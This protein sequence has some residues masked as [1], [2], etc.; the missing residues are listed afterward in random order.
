M[1]QFLVAVELLRH[2]EL[3]G[4]PVVVGGRGDPTERAVVS[5]A[6]YEARALR[7]PQRAC[8]SSRPSG[9]RPDAVFLPVDFPVYEAASARVM[10]T[11]RGDAGGR[12]RGARLGRG[13]RGRRDRR[14]GGHRAGRCRP[15]VLEATGLHCSVGIGDTLVRAKIATDF[16]KPQGV[17]E[18]TRDNWIEVMGERP[19][20]ALWGVGH[21]DRRSGSTQ[22]G[23]RTVRRPRGHRRRAARRR[24]RA[25]QRARTSAGSVAA[26]AAR[27]P[28]TPRGW[29][30]PTA[31]RR[32]TRPTCSRPTT[33]APRCA[34]SPRGS[35]TT[36]ARRSG[37]V[38]AGA[39][40]GPVR[41]V[42]HLHPHPQ[43]RPRRR[44]TSR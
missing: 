24:V 27:V 32:P 10:E 39:P 7:R 31:G 20:T 2:P 23:I 4:L 26:A 25:D 9:A 33:Y 17:F 38:P 43:A 12:G 36:S 19:T 14:P 13:V 41:A 16:G 35:S 5:T 40:Q 34:S 44:T 6:S 22:I 18:L 1:D 37:R 29:R 11:L 21:E 8:R 15:A 30:A 28:T 42:L 3:A